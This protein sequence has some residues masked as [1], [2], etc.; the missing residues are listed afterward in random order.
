MT[1]NTKIE[2]KEMRMPG[3][4]AESSLYRGSGYLSLNGAKTVESDE[5]KVIPA[6]GE[7]V[8]MPHHICYPKYCLRQVFIPGTIPPQFRFVKYICGYVCK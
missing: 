8:P 7:L 5:G 4:N 1:S 2:V 6:G 3:F